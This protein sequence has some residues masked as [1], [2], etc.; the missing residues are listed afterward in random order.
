MCDA[1]VRSGVLDW[2]SRNNFRQWVTVSLR[3]SRS[4]PIGGWRSQSRELVVRAETADAV[5]PA[6]AEVERLT[7][8][9]GLHAVGYV[10]YE[11]GGAFGLDVH[12]PITGLPLVWFALYDTA[13]VR[14]AEPPARSA[15]YSLGPLEPSLDR[16]AFLQAFH[17]IKAHLAGGESYQVNFTFQMT[18]PFAGDPMDLFADLVEAQRGRYSAYLD[19]GDRVIC[20]ASPELFFELRG[21]EVFARPMKGTARRGRT[22]E[23]D[24]EARDRLQSSAKDRAENVMVVDMVRNDLGRIADVGTVRVEALFTVERYPNVWQMTSLVAARSLA[25]LDEMFAALHP[26]ASITGA[27]K[28][29]TMEIVRQLEA[30]PRGVYTGAI[31]HVPPDGQ[32]RFNVAIR[33]AVIDRPAGVLSF[34]VGSGIVWDSDGAAEYDE[35]LL[36]GSIVGTASPPFELLETLR[37]T[38]GAGYYLLD[39]HLARLRASAEYFGIELTD[40][41]LDDALEKAV[42]GVDAA[43]RVRLLVA[44]TG[45]CRTERRPHVATP[46]ALR[47]AVASRPIDP[48]SIWLFHKT[49]H[50]A[51]YDAARTDAPECDDVILWNEDG[52]VTEATNANVVVELDGARVTPPIRCGLLP[53]TFRAAMLDAGDVREGVVTLD[54]LRRATGIWLIN[55]VHEARPAVLIS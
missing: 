5:R 46:G 24:T 3:D 42:E 33:T 21:A 38:P 9:R 27:P 40:A 44:R 34:G 53:G 26:S 45:T 11:A 29:R 54:D 50:R 32:A 10:A 14:T 1:P 17:T 18:A 41:A 55:S 52:H 23:E 6:I 2:D 36:K 49:T 19:I 22:L 4:T 47:V 13:G 7:R 31:G 12:A 25:P 48:R 28:V 15:A 16:Q 51:I 43:Q 20:S 35:C 30:G 37:W 39:R 8:D